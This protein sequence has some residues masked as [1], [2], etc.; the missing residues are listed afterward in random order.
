MYQFLPSRNCFCEAVYTP[1]R[2]NESNGATQLIGLLAPSISDSLVLCSLKGQQTTCYW[3]KAWMNPW[4]WFAPVYQFINHWGDRALK[5]ACVFCLVWFLIRDCRCFS[6][7]QKFLKNKTLAVKD[8]IS[9]SPFVIYSARQGSGFIISTAGTLLTALAVVSP[10]LSGA[11]QLLAQLQAAC[12]GVSSERRPLTACKTLLMAK[13]LTSSITQVQRLYLSP[14]GASHT[15][16]HIHTHWHS[17][18][19]RTC[20]WAIV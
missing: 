6:T 14:R 7:P 10:A 15:G 8:Q 11:C 13:T 2:L 20:L 5:P 16:V 19:A 17:R 9:P 4:I 12:H 1:R 3:W 18:T